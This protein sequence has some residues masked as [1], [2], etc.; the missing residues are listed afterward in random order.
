[1]EIWGRPLC[2]DIS[3]RMYSIVESPMRG[4]CGKKEHQYTA[5][6]YQDT[7]CSRFTHCLECHD[8]PIEDCPNW[9]SERG[10]RPRKTH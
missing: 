6:C 1:L 7:G 8:I 3:Q 4:D 10:G 5:S 2:K 9:Q